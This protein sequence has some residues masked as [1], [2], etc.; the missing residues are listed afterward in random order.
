M[1]EPVGIRLI[2]GVEADIESEPVL[3]DCVCDAFSWTLGA[4]P[5][6][7]A[8]EIEELVMAEEAEG[9]TTGPRGAEPPEG[10]AAIDVEADTDVEIGTPARYV[11]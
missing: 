2:L 3:L 6:V 4:S 11:A 9:I 7:E 1:E 8:F 5:A 10:V